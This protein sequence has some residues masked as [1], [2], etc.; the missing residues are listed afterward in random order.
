MVSV[1]NCK[2][3]NQLNIVRGEFKFIEKL[4]QLMN[5]SD[6]RHGSQNGYFKHETDCSKFW[7]C[8]NGKP[9]MNECPHTLAFNEINGNCDW[10]LTCVTSSKHA[11]PDGVNDEFTCPQEPA[12]V[13]FGGYPEPR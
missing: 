11:Q 5:L 12:E 9:F 7:Q 6:C 10:S 1:P 3:L 8:V 13:D 2:S 4:E